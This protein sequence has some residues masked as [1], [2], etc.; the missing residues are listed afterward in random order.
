M[1]FK[2]ATICLAITTIGFAIWGFMT[3]R[4][5]SDEQA[6]VSQEQNLIDNQKSAITASQAQISQLEQNYTIGE[7]VV[8][9]QQAALVKDRKDFDAAV[10]AA[11]A[12]QKNLNLQLEVARAHAKLAQ[13]CAA[14]L[15]NGHTTIYADVP[16]GVTIQQVAKAAADASKPCKGIVTFTP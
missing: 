16:T 7:K 8:A 4:S 5:L 14:S 2:I 1:G 9:A 3:Y 10:V 13:A 6:T 11:K 15:A 12:E